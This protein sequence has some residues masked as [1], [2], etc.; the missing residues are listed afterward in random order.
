MISAIIVYKIII[1][2]AWIRNIL[3]FAAWTLIILFWRNCWE[4]WGL[5]LRFGRDFSQSHS[6]HPAHTSKRLHNPI[7]A[8]FLR[9]YY[10]Q[11]QLA[12]L[13]LLVNLVLQ[14]LPLLLMR[15]VNWINTWHLVYRFCEIVPT[16]AVGGLEVAAAHVWQPD[17][18]TTIGTATI[19][20]T[21]RPFILC[22]AARWWDARVVEWLIIQRNRRYLQLAATDAHFVCR[23]TWGAEVRMLFVG[24]L[25]IQQTI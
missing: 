3:W 21:A 16:V 23:I 13:D 1:D 19:A 20:S 4:I 17:T 15:P 5:I 24:L 2:R 6:N 9:L 11:F 12:L 8:A 18:R 25:G 7:G 14:F 10:L 22:L